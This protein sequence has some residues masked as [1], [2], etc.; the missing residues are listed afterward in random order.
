MKKDR[1]HSKEARINGTEGHSRK[2]EVPLAA[3]GGSEKTEF[4]AALQESEKRYRALFE[5]AG[6]A[7][8]ILDAEGENPGKIVTANQAA[9]RMH[10]YTIEEL[11]T[12]HITD[13][14]TPDSAKDA[15]LVIQRILA[16]EWVKEEI[17]HRK[18]N[19]TVFPVEMSAGLLSA[20][21]HRY[22]LAFDRDITERKKAEKALREREAEYRSLV[23]STEDSIY[24]VDRN[25]RYLFMNKKHLTRLGLTEDSFRSKRYGDIHSPE[26][27]EVFV[28]KVDGVFETGT[29]VRHEHFSSRDRRYFL[30]TLSPVRDENGA[31]VAVTVISKDITELKE[32]EER[33]RALSLTD[34]LTG[35]YNRRGFFVLADQLLKF[36][37]RQNK[38]LFMLYADMDKLKG[39]NDSLGHHA[40]DRALA[41]TAAVL[42]ETYRESDIIARIG[43]DEFVV[44]PIGGGEDNIELITGRMREQVDT[45]NA[46]RDDYTISISFGVSCFDP[47][48]PCTI[49]ELLA[50]AEQRMYEQKRGKRKA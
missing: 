36:A 14:D 9:A 30:R 37:K 17:T 2:L 50:E 5:G 47:E 20:D 24:L 48:R 41:D 8:F 39:I 46:C 23:E 4:E 25:Y 11:L 44:L 28:S 1:R 22:V 26:E 27:T 35:L 33:L 12:L 3:G 31:A 6:D 42:K 21:N 10:G 18:K 19:G 29:S 45:L 43:G 7:I 13:L 40:G 32:M 34:E 16:G 15:P 38:A 49:D